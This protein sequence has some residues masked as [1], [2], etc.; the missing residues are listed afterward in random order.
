MWCGGCE[1]AT[2]HDS[3]RVA[4]VRLFGLLCG[5][6]EII[7]LAEGCNYKEVDSWICTMDHC[8]SAVDT[9]T[10]PP[11]LHSKLRRYA[12]ALGLP[13]TVQYPVKARSR[14]AQDHECVGNVPSYHHFLAESKSSI[15]VGRAV[16]TAQGQQ[17]SFNCLGRG[18]THHN[19]MQQEE[20]I[21]FGISQSTTF[22]VGYYLLLAIVEAKMG[23]PIKYTNHI[24]C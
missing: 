1:F 14:E 17:L 13:R 22:G 12:S 7:Y 4:F 21:S 24:K 11:R 23:Q 15:R 10:R 18:A 5:E 19:A 20:G 9:T 16:T 3:T 6:F 8:Y 2:W